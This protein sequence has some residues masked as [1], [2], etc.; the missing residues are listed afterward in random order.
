MTATLP[1]AGEP[2]EVARR[3]L[4]ASGIY[5]G[6]LDVEREVEVFLSEMERGLAGS[7]SS[8]RMLPTFIEVDRDVPRGRPVV[9]IDA[10]GTH[11][12]AAV[13][14]FGGDG[15]PSV[16][17]FRRERMPGS[18]EEVSS[19]EFFAA[20]AGFVRDLAPHSESIGFS[21]SYPVEMLPSKDGRIIGLWKLRVRDAAGQLV[22][23][24]LGAAL[25]ESGVRSPRNVVVL[26]DGVAVLLAGRTATDD[27][28][29]SF[30][31]FVLG[32]GMNSSYVE[33]NAR[34]VKRGDLPP[35]RAQVINIESGAYERAARGPLDLRFDE[36]SASPGRYVFQKCISGGY[37]GGLTLEVLR[38]AADADLFGP[39]AAATIRSVDHLETRELNPFLGGEPM[40][41]SLHQVI[42]A[43]GDAVDV[44][45]AC[46]LV[47]GVVE[48]AARLAAISIAAAVRKAAEAHAT[49]APVHV[50]VD[51]STI[52]R[53]QTFENRVTSCLEALLGH[54]VR[55]E[56]VAVEHA[57]LV[58]AAV[59]ALTN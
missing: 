52:L 51:G 46:Q 29:G 12:R 54:R 8:L 23:A 5:H 53:L 57:A 26:N 39:A 18:T 49:S 36:A 25:H 16:T 27:R 30:V 56:L 33:S 1:G 17:A 6:D 11:L 44:A 20:L 15:K 41:G 58:G 3:F 9:A 32:T 21:F 14:E 59:A 38:S 47:D 2:R 48:R 31:G 55:Y 24:N 40:A 50:S 7:P 4:Q 43:G 34:I 19:R 28:E 42:C 13:V 22:G 35:G 10:G 45:M 37:L